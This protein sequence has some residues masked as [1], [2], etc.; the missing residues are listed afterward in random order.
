MREEK[1]ENPFYDLAWN[2][3]L[4]TV[5][6][7]TNGKVREEREEER[8]KFMEEEVKI[9]EREDLD[10]FQGEEIVEAGREVE[11]KGASVSKMRTRSRW[12]KHPR[13]TSVTNA[14]YPTF[15]RFS[16]RTHLRLFAKPRTNHRQSL[17]VDA[18]EV[19][20]IY[21]MVWGKEKE[22]EKKKRS[23]GWRLEATQ[24]REPSIMDSFNACDLILHLNDENLKFKKGFG[25]T[26]T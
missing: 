22:E 17:L 20:M 18:M 4:Q 14:F 7:D 12:M 13:V 9:E 15:T 6:E 21:Y 16:R 5:L 19:S 2:I 26:E 10:C 3:A 1:Q 11:E 24:V 25:W 23:R 8:R